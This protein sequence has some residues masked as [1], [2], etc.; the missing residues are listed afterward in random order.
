MAVAV[1]VVVVV[2]VDVVG[3]ALQRR[4][5]L[6]EPTGTVLGKAEQLE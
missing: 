4:L 3:T 2:V 1:V 5:T 6:V